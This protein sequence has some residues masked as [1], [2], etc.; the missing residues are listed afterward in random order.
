MVLRIFLIVV[1][2]AAIPTDFAVG[3][4]IVG[5]V[6]APFLIWSVIDLRRDHFLDQPPVSGERQGV[7]CP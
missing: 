6:L 1:Y 2:A 4:W 5:A 7:G 3:R